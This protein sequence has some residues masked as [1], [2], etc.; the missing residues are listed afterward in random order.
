MLSCE[1]EFSQREENEVLRKEI[2]E[3][4]RE[5]KQLKQE[6][7]KEVQKVDK[8]HDEVS[9]QNSREVSQLSAE[10][11]MLRHQA[12][13]ADTASK[14]ERAKLGRLQ[15]DLAKVKGQLDEKTR[16]VQVFATAIY[17]LYL[18]CSFDCHNCF[19]PIFS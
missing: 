3:L 1:I 9:K 13:M 5:M 14:A 4:H 17:A 12:K 2:A 19:S 16:L 6:H 11:E 10:I 18:S 7:R 15:D 8:G